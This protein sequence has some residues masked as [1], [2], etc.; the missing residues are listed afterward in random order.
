MYEE[1]TPIHFLVDYENVHYEGLR[2]VEFLNSSDTV[3]I[4][5]SPSCPKITMK[6]L[7]A[8]IKSGCTFDTCKLIK[9][10]SK[11]ALDFYI[12]VRVGEEL[13]KNEES[14]LVIV[15]KDNGFENVVEYAKRRYI[16]CNIATASTIE[17]GFTTIKGSDYRKQMI[18]DKSSY[19]EFKDVF[20]YKKSLNPY[21]AILEKANMK[22]IDP[23]RLENITCTKYNNGRELYYAVIKEFG[24]NDG[25]PIYTALK[26]SE[27]FNKCLAK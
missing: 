22:S 19:V 2:G 5:Y 27:V 18:A 7:E 9:S 3:T 16:K 1:F 25:R 6:D 11:N 10:P 4:F 17:H 24:M 23:K 21:Q 26:D 13:A 20:K 14:T 8:V 12:A 15:S